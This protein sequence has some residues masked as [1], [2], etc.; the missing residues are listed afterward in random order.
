MCIR[1]SRYARDE[2]FVTGPTLVLNIILKSLGSV[3]SSPLHWS[4]IWSS[5]NLSPQL[6]QSIRG[7]VNVSS[8]PE[9]LRTSGWVSIDVSKPSTS[10]LL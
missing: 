7:S 9:Y 4:G 10:S 1:D 6:L 3:S 2:S 8:W 5:L